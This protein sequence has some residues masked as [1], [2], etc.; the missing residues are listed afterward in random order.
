MRKSYYYKFRNKTLLAC[1]VAL[2]HIDNAVPRK[3]EYGNCDKKL[4]C[5]LFDFSAIPAAVI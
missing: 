2:C 1:Y 4:F 5:L 3:Q